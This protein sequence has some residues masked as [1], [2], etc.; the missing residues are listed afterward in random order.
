MGIKLIFPQT[1]LPNIRAAWSK[2][3]K[4]LRRKI[5]KSRMFEQTWA[6]VIRG[7]TFQREGI[8]IIHQAFSGKLWRARNKPWID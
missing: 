7:G 1:H 4:H 3:Q 5:P 6:P 8:H 2:R